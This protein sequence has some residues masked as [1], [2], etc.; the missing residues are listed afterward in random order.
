MIS[1][2][3]SGQRI[4]AAMAFVCALALGFVAEARD[5]RVQGTDLGGGGAYT[6]RVSAE[7]IGNTVKV[8]WVVGNSRYTGTGVLDGDWLAVYFT[9]PTT[10]VALY[11]VDDRGAFHGKWT[12]AGSTQ[13]GTEDWIPVR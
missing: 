7:V 5:F 8:T 12:T 1:I 3:K 13:V 6:G 11:R 2:R 10:G 4:L 9:G